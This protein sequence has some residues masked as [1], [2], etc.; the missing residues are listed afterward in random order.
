MLRSI[1]AGIALMLLAY[2]SYA[3][4]RITHIEPQLI[5]NT[6]SYSSEESLYSSLGESFTSFLINVNLSISLGF[7]QNSNLITSTH[8]E[9]I[10][11]HVSL[12]PNP[13]SGLLNICLLYTS[14]SPRDRG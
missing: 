12:F 2:V 4:T 3:Q 13:T 1:L 5:A 6:G 8:G 14:P 9:S 11:T 7:Y 10:I